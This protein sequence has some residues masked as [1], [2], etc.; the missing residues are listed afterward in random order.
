MGLALRVTSDL[1]DPGRAEDPD[2]QRAADRREQQRDTKRDVTA[3]AEVTDLDALRVLE[4]EDQQQDQYD[5]PGHEAAERGRRPGPRWLRL[6]LLR[7]TGRRNGG[8]IGGY[9]LSRS[10]RAHGLGCV[11]WSRLG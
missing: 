8:G 2:E 5:R 6:E 10:S 11:V 7:L 3:R 9:R 1:R 4:D